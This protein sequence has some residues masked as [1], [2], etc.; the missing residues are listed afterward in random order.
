MV[1]KGFAGGPT[2]G[3]HK[4]VT[5]KTPPSLC[6]LHQDRFQP[7]YAVHDRLTVLSRCKNRSNVLLSFAS[8]L[9]LGHSCTKHGNQNHCLASSV[10]FGCAMQKHPEATVPIRYPM[11]DS[12]KTDLMPS[13]DACSP[14]WVAER[15]S[16]TWGEWEDGPKVKLERR[17]PATASCAAGGG[18]W[19]ED[20]KSC[21]ASLQV[22][23]CNR[24]PSHI[25]VRRTACVCTQ[26]GE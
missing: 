15:A 14:K 7:I 4:H 23:A 21:A 26:G 12:C 9:T 25:Y 16:T 10:L 3:L 2:N 8:S 24:R 5:C 17:F 19:L 6:L 11:H 20:R 22:L 18:C 13:A 1:N